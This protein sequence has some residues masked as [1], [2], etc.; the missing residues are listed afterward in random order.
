[1]FESLGVINVW[2]CLTGLFAKSRG[3]VMFE[4]LGVI[5]AWTCLTGLFSKSRG[6][7]HV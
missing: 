6:A 1:M 5:N 7:R 3:G 2:T 4:S